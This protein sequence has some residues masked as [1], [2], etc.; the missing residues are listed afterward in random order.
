LHF[1]YLLTYKQY[2]CAPIILLSAYSSI[3]PSIVC[4]SEI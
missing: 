4:Q 1:L 2:S 3:H